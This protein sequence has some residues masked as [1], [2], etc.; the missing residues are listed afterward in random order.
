VRGIPYLERA[1]AVIGGHHERYDGRGYPNGL[2]GAQI[3][4]AARIF[5]VADTL[6]AMTSDRPYRRAGSFPDALAEIRRHSGTQ[7]DPRVVAALAAILADLQQWRHDF[8]PCEA[9][10]RD[11][12]GMAVSETVL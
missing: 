10:R 4:L 9:A 12:L 2:A 5:A 1:A 6:D 11:P 3:P 8:Q 7:F